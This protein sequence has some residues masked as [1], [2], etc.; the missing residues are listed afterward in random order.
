MSADERPF[1][2]LKSLR[3]KNLN[4][5][6]IA[7]ININSIRNKFD[8]LSDL[9]VGSIDVLLI[10]ETKIDETFPSAQFGISGY[11]APYRLDRTQ[12]GGGLL[13]YL[14]KDIPSK[15]LYIPGITDTTNFEC[16]FVEINLHKIKWL[17][18]GTYNPS[19]NNIATHLSKL[20]SCI[21]KFSY[22]Y[23]NLIILGDF[24]AEPYH[25]EVQE[26][27]NSFN[28]KNLVKEPTCYKNYDN[29]SC[30]DLIITNRPRSF[31]N[32]ITLETG[33]SDFHKMNL[34]V[35]KSSLKKQPPKIIVYRAII[36]THQKTFVE[37]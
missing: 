17:I 36:S 27:C 14:R 25:N 21:E 3:A 9:F 22:D 12:F 26:F 13:L 5:I 1:F 37:N 34:T 15:I 10:S 8:I 4:R 20:S 33:I 28:M 23:D 32:T 19:K 30:I 24:N 31:Q 11:S 16:L 6:I 29:P 7:H 2:V 18:C 35:L